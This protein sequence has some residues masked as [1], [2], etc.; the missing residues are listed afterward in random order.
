MNR[1]SER[2]AGTIREPVLL[3]EWIGGDGP[4]SRPAVAR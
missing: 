3:I 4:S 1:R 2:S